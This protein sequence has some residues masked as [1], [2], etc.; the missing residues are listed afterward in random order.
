MKRRHS[1]LAL[2]LALGQYAHA[3]Q[4]PTTVYRQYATQ[5]YMKKLMA[6]HPEMVEARSAI[7]RHT[8]D[9]QRSGMLDTPTIQ[10]VFHLMGAAAANISLL[11]VQAQLDALN[12][13]FYLPEFLP[14]EI[15]HPA[16]TAES[17]YE[18]AAKPSIQFCLA[19]NDPVGTSTRGVLYMNSTAASFPIGTEITKPDGGGSVAWDPDR[20]LN[21]WVAPLENDL[22]GYAQM[23][24]GPKESDGIVINASLFAR[25]DK[26]SF[27]AV[28][29]DIANY[30]SGRT[31]THLV[32]SY[33]NLYELWNDDQPCTDDYVND[34]P[35]HNAPNYGVPGY[36]HISVCGDNPVEMTMNLMDNTDDEAQYMFT[37]GQVMR[38]YAVLSVYGGARAG[39]RLPST[40]C[41]SNGNIE[42]GVDGRNA[43]TEREP[44]AGK[45]TISVYPNPAKDGFTVMINSLCKEEIHLEA[46]NELGSPQYAQ[47]L[48]NGV[49]GP[50]STVY[51]NTQDW[52]PGLYVV[53]AQCGKE[54]AV[55][56]VLLER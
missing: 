8:Y 54:A 40:A 10:V 16:W 24:G 42:A 39:L 17:Y 1:L 35:I 2:L 13:D 50:T 3:Q 9:F 26:E 7:E 56:K 48:S 25:A 22:A 52:A 6:D 31:L 45:L 49:A 51:V 23:P 20:Y 32:G 44:K 11:D 53:R 47:A 12:R 33:L 4:E 5:Q 41:S 19:M 46:M 34:T 43:I 27:L 30:A 55:A 14:K 21:I 37:I 38:M 18:R 28:S 29:P 15:E 36:R